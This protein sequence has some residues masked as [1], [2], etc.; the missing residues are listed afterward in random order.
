MFQLNIMIGIRDPESLHIQFIWYFPYHFILPLVL[1]EAS[2]Q[3]IHLPEFSRKSGVM[4]EETE[5]HQIYMLM[6]S[7]NSAFDVNTFEFIFSVPVRLWS[8]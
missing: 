3:L 4:R 6:W 2:T 1:E 8:V 5:Q 7:K